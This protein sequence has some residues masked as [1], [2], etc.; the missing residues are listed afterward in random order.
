MRKMFFATAASL[1]LCASAFAVTIPNTTLMATPATTNFVYPGTVVSFVSNPGV[2]G[3]DSGNDVWDGLHI[4]QGSNTS[5]TFN[6]SQPVSNFA[7]DF[8]AHSNVNDNSERLSNFVPATWSLTNNSVPSHETSAV[9][10]TVV[11][12]VDDGWGTVTFN[13]GPYNA[14]S[15][16][17][18]YLTGQPA[19]T[20]L[21]ELRY[22]AV[23]PEPATLSL[24]A[25]GALTLL[26]RR[27]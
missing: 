3:L 2:S 23:V 9:G 14:V 17:L 11:P 12:L 20:V 16:D 1:S 18:E 19:G 4:G 13:N 15:F 21:T 27:R 6:F 24:V 8:T 5:I 25:A 22:D 10:N 7:F 26:R